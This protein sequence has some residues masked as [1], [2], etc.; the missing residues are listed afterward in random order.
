MRPAAA[1][2][3][4]AAILA[5]H[6]APAQPLGPPA[7]AVRTITFEGPP[8]GEAHLGDGLVSMLEGEIFRQ[9]DAGGAYEDCGAVVVDVRNREAAEREIALQQT[10]YFDPATRLEP[11]QFIEPTHEVSGHL[12]LEGGR[13]EW[14]VELREMP[15][16]RTVDAVTGEA[17]E[18][19]YFD[20]AERI[21]NDLVSRL[22]DKAYTASGGGAR[23]QVSG[24]VPRL[25]APFRLVGEFQGGTALFNYTPDETGGGTVSYVLMGSGVTGS[26]QGTFTMAPQPDGTVKI[27]QSTNGCIDGM[28]NSCRE[29]SETIT[30]TPA[31]R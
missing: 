29:N 14:I 11:G 5:P 31:K 3:L 21:A 26:G 23:I 10:E 18:D 9:T 7:I 4:F 2:A 20:I 13:L 16:G 8:G 15:G 30:L 25:D 28:A 1:I 19:A 24:F 22:C 6:A 17:P 27:E 12:R